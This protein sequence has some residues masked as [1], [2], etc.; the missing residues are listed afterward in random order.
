M[1]LTGKWKYREKKSVLYLLLTI[2]VIAG[3]PAGILALVVP[4][5]SSVA[6]LDFICTCLG[7]AWASFCLVYV[8][9]LVQNK[10]HWI[11]YEEASID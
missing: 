4:A 9:S 2:I 11:S 3:I 8:L 5:L 1:Y 7:A 10:Y 6:I